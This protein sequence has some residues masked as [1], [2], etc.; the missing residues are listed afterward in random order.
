MKTLIRICT[1]FLFPFSCVY[2]LHQGNPSMPNAIEKGLFF[3]K[4]NFIAVKAG[5]LGD[6][7]WGGDYKTENGA[8]S[9]IKSYHS[10]SHS[11]LFFVNILNQ[12]EGY[13]LLGTMKGDFTHRPDFDGRKRKYET[14][15]HPIWGGGIRFEVY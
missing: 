8:S 6:V 14:A 12:I 10:E 4:E 9:S 7:V 1:F 5:Y 11:G 13:G 15:F 3:C 2:A